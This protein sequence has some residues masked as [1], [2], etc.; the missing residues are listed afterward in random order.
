MKKETINSIRI[1]AA[2]DP[3]VTPEQVEN[4]VRACE[5]KQVHRQLIT[6]N[7]A[8]QI[9][10]GE[11]P[12]SKVTLGKWIKQGKVTPVKISRRIYRYDRLE[13]ERLAYG[14]QA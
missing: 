14:G 4:I 1:L 7:E 13:I 3:T 11:R 10:G 9:I 12:I 2:A 5:V 6:G 8:R